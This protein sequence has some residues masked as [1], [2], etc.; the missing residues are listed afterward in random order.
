ME[1]FLGNI[2]LPT[3]LLVA[4]LIAIVA[5]IFYSRHTM[6]KNVSFLPEAEFAQMMRKGQLID[7]RKKDEF[8]AGHINGSRN[9][10]F[11]M[12]TKSMSKLRG[13]Q[14]IFLVCANDKQ[15]HRVTALLHAKNFTKVYALKGGIAGWSKP[16]K[17]KK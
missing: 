3:V 14:P 2:S 1:N 10:P 4:L 8:E 7:V 17:T 5:L 6:K 15:S 11:A 9:L 16:L 13:D 12:L